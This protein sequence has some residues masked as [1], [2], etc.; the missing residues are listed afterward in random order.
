M[1]YKNLTLTH[2]LALDFC[3]SEDAVSDRYNHFT[4]YQPLPGRRRFER[5]ERDCFLKIAVYG[6]KLLVTGRED[7][8]SELERR[9]WNTGGAWFFEYPTM[10][11]LDGLFHEY[12]YTLH[13]MHPFYIADKK[14]EL[15]DDPGRDYTCVRYEAV[16]IE[17]FRG[18][19]RFDEAFAFSPCA[20]DVL[21]YAA[22][23]KSDGAILGM[24]GASADSPFL[25]QIGIN[26]IPEARG[27]GVACDLV[28]RLKNEILDL[29]YLPYYG[30]SVSHTAS[31]N[32]ALN[33][34]FRPAWVELIT[35]KLP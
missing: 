3:C 16:E 18:D 35:E 7:I 5:T 11:E 21:A 2:Q 8:V 30:M 10:R 29:G 1:L 23:R 15:P 9:Y 20:P 33:A 12:G 4:N 14:S 22:V 25:W 34:G 31:Q 26:V 24:A 6:G 19:E 27:R 17:Q 28:A 32:V 13:T